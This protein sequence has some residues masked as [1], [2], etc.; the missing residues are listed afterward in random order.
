FAFPDARDA[1]GKRINLLDQCGNCNPDA[2]EPYFASQVMA[3]TPE[4]LALVHAESGA[5]DLRQGR[6][7]L[8][9]WRAATASNL[10]VRIYRDPADADHPEIVTV[11]V[12]VI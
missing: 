10:E 1:E 12:R 9:S 7:V 2:F 4:L 8:V 3:G 11:P 5:E 6:A